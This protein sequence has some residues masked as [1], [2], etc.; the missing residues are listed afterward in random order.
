MKVESSLTESTPFPGRLTI[1][2]SFALG[3]LDVEDT[4]GDISDERFLRPLLQ[5]LQTLSEGRNSPG[6]FKLSQISSVTMTLA[7]M[8]I[9]GADIAAHVVTKQPNIRLGHLLVQAT[10]HSILEVHDARLDLRQL[11][12]LTPLKNNLFITPQWR[13]DI[14]LTPKVQLIDVMT[15]LK[16]LCHKWT[17]ADIGLFNVDHKVC[18]NILSSLT[19]ESSQ[20]SFRSIVLS[21][22]KTDGSVANTATVEP[23]RFRGPF[24]VVFCD[25]EHVRETKTTLTQ[26]GILAVLVQG[27]EY[28]VFEDDDLD[29]IGRVK[30]SFDRQFLLYRV[31]AKP[32]DRIS[33]RVRCFCHHA[34]NE[35]LQSLLHQRIANLS[36]DSDARGVDDVQFGEEQHE[37]IALDNG[38][39]SMLIGHA[40]HVL[41]PWMQSLL[42]NIQLFLWITINA[43][44]D[45]L[46]DVAGSCMRTIANENPAVSIACLSIKDNMSDEMIV[47]IIVTVLRRLRD[48]SA[49]TEIIFKDNEFHCLRYYP[50]N[51]LSHLTGVC[52]PSLVPDFRGE[53]NHQIVLGDDAK[54]YACV[55]RFPRNSHISQAMVRVTNKFSAVD[56]V[57]LAAA[58][59]KLSDYEGLGHFLGGIV[60]Q[61]ASNAFAPND[62]VVGYCPGAHRNSIDVPASQLIAVSSPDVIP[63]ALVSFAT[64]FTAIATLEYTARIRRRDAVRLQLPHHLREIFRYHFKRL[65]AIEVFGDEFDFFL[66]YDAARG[67]RINGQHLAPHSLHRMSQDQSS[68]ALLSTDLSH[69]FNTRSFPVSDVAAAFEEGRKAPFQT[70]LSHGTAHNKMPCILQTRDSLLFECD[71]AYVLVGGSGGLGRH[72]SLWMASRG[73]RNIFIITRTMKRNHEID[74]WQ[75]DMRH[76]GANLEIL[77][78]DAAEYESLENH[79]C[80]IRSRMRIIGCINMAMVLHDAPFLSTSIEQWEQTLEA[81]VR[82]TL[83]LHRASLVDAPALFIVFSSLASLLGNRMQAAYATANSYQNAFAHLRRS[84]GL[85]SVSIALGPVSEIGVLSE[86]SSLKSIYINSGLRLL[87]KSDLE[88]MLQAAVQECYYPS[89]RVVIGAGLRTLK[90]VNGHLRDEHVDANQC[91][92]A[93]MAEFSP[94]IEYCHDSKIEA[95]AASL[96]DR[97]RTNIGDAHQTLLKEIITFLSSLIG[98]PAR[99]IR[100]ATPLAQ[101]GLDS[102]S[103]VSFRYWIFKG[104]IIFYAL[105][106]HV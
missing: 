14:S 5:L 19:D 42:G 35:N 38:H 72:V 69:K 12:R 39:Q 1:R 18:L 68:M 80:S 8:S 100:P 94:M 101:Y 96:R 53:G 49:E 77:S 13:T 75:K 34:M 25:N 55:D 87:S 20:L 84:Q 85:A 40:K 79:L 24:H 97:I 102:L 93:E 98:L 82:T 90:N 33:N 64:H 46:K 74:Q 52:R 10:Q 16:M 50:D 43:D 15:L 57:D 56:H 23:E 51:H 88:K 21:G 78:G 63:E 81:K 92:W 106:F 105:S 22:C 73:A 32:P 104:L 9:L 28:T 60:C 62:A 36:I 41:L 59:H 61:S 11:S 86:N 17:M 26:D 7:K 45:P 3:S 27:T 95:V 30:A 47:D 4:V 58:F 89:H 44:R 6:I 76:C 48:G 29:S 70:L 91:F 71:G 2:D 83:N 103:A 37:G 65:G 66:E 99:D 54:P 31:Q 67:L